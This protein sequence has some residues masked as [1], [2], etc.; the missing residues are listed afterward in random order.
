[1]KIIHLGKFD[2][3]DTGGIENHVNNLCKGLASKKINVINIISNRAFKFKRIFKFNYEIISLPAFFRFFSTAINIFLPIYVL[4]KVF[5][6][7][8]NFIHIHHPDPLSHFTVLFLPKR[9]KI[10]LTWHCDIHAYKFLYF[11]YK[12]LLKN[13]L[14]RVDHIIVAT[15]KHISSSDILNNIEYKH[16]ISIIP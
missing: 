1:M 9:I 4:K 12:P 10:I 15:P 11:F 6:D 8:Y 13:L 14:K 7:R 16:K 5:Y 3:P 2:E